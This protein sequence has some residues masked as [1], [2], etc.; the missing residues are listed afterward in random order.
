MHSSNIEIWWWVHQTVKSILYFC[1]WNSM[2]FECSSI[3]LSP[4]STADN[5][6]GVMKWSF[7]THHVGFYGSTAIDSEGTI[8]VTITRPVNGIYLMDTRILLFC[9]PFIIGKITIQVEATLEPFDIDRVLS[10]TL[11]TRLKAIDIEAPYEWT[12]STPAFFK[13]SPSERLLT[14]PLVIA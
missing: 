3:L 4:Y 12:W 9:K 10:S 5:P 7:E 2:H 13:H 1:I 6:P 11:M 14:T 8:S